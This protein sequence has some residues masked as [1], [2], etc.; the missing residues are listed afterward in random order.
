MKHIYNLVLLTAAMLILTACGLRSRSVEEAE[1]LQPNILIIFT[2]DQG[3]ADLGCYGSTLHQT[4]HLDRLAREGTRFTSFY[5]QHVCGPSRSAL[6]TGRYPIRSLGWGMPAE[7]I[8]WAEL[9]RNTGYQTACIG[10]WDVSNRKPIIERMPNAQGFEYYF[11]TLGANDHGYVEF[12][13]DTSLVGATENMGSL[14]RFYTNKAIDFLRNKRDDSR[15][16]ALYLAHTMMHMNIDASPALTGKSR[17]GLYGDVV[18]EFDHETGRL[19]DMLEELQLTDHT[20]VI[21]TTD[22]GPWNQEAYIDRK[23][24]EETYLQWKEEH[25]NFANDEKFWGDSGPLRNGKGSCYEGGV[26][27]PCIM[28][29]P[30]QVPAGKVSD[31][32]FATIDFLP[33]F[34]SLAGTAVPADRQMDGVDQTALL[35]GE[36]EEGNRDSFFY[37]NGYRLGRW[38]YLAA[39]HTIY[40]YSRDPDREI[41]EELYDLSV[42]IGETTNLAT[43]YP[44]KVNEL[45]ALMEMEREGSDTEILDKIR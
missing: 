15:P 12:Y 44:E 26:R 24:E 14:T 31:A 23:R 39:E 33:T 19:L 42:D 2:D 11:G 16:F 3:Y 1:P 37:V 34:A 7:E 10:K 18:E 36:S 41:T 13:E 29:W 21:Y 28:R 6:L 38:K 22:N 32:I 27:V 30:G 40:G 4:P 20:L 35:L 17:G 45:R 8:T 25:A 43:R 5:A 9:L